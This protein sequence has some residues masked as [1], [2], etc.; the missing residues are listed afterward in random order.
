MSD[1]SFPKSL[2]WGILIVFVL[3]S[4]AA[5]VIKQAELSRSQLPV[6]GNVPHFQFEAQNGESFG[7]QDILGV[8]NV[9]AF[10]FTNCPSACP[11]MSTHLGKLYQLFSASNA[12]R[13]VAITVDPERDTQPV[14]QQYAA[15]HGVVDQRWIFLRAPI[16]QV[17]ALSEKGFMLAAEN[18][19]MGHSTR[20]VLV[21]HQG[22][23]RGYYDGLS[24]SSVD[25]LKSSIVELVKAM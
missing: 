12:V 23:I 24:E 15:D 9:F 2:L 14:L 18:L 16:D 6:H 22:Q 1:A 5:I 7:R 25:A 4:G 3:A 8:I 19:P 20:F 11:V 21:D 10:I 13:F 17:V